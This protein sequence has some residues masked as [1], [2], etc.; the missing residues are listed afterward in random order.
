[1]RRDVMCLTCQLSHSSQEM[2][3]QLELKVLL[4][5][6]FSKWLHVGLMFVFTRGSLYATEVCRWRTIICLIAFIMS[7]GVYPTVRHGSIFAA[8]IWF[9]LY[10]F[11]VIL[12][13]L[14]VT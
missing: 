8:I 12:R 5:S 7:A 10:S 14:F 2:V 1:M 9:S 13:A 3:T 6:V 11:F 4:S